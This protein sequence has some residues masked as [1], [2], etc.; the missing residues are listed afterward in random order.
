M[1]SLHFSPI[2]LEFIPILHFPCLAGPF[3]LAA[4][5]S[6]SVGAIIP[7]FAGSELVG[8]IIA[9]FAGSEFGRLLVWSC[10]RVVCSSDSTTLELW[11]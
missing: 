4:Q 3:S 7:E 8:A 9:E 2:K 5:L 11:K 1:L 10:K 6:F